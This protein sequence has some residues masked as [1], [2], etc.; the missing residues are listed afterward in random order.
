MFSESVTTQHYYLHVP[1]TAGTSVARWLS[2]SGRFTICPDGLWSF[3][4][5]RKKEDL[6]QY[7]LFCGHFYR[8]LSTYLGHPLQTFTFVRNPFDR[9][10]S[11]Y[12]HVRRDHHHYFHE[13]VRAQGSFLAFLRDPVTQPLVKN[14]QTRAF[15]AIFDPANAAD[16]LSHSPNQ[17]YPLEQYLETTDSGLDDT[18]ALLLAKDF[19]ARCIFVGI[20]EQMQKSVSQLAGILGISGGHHIEYLN[21]NPNAVSVDSLSQEEWSAL[22]AL[23]ETDW[24]LYEFAL[25][26][27]RNY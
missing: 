14:F 9:A 12:E 1:K 7:S 6:S 3:L 19:L 13:R 22:A 4:L 8:Y 18:K 21:K 23:L 24:E 27:F 17:P 5:K 16:A 20:S 2:D 25:R 15:S 26:Q 10:L 11:H